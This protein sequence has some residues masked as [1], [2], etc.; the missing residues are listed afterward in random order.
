MNQT[1]F[2]LGTRA[3]SFAEL[4]LV[5]LAVLV[6][7]VLYLIISIHRSRR[8]A[9]AQVQAEA[10]RG[11][12][13]ETH[14]SELMRIQNEL[15]GRMQTMAEVFGTRQSDLFKAVSERMD[16]M[17]HRLGQSMTEHN[18]STNDTLRALQ[19]RLAVIDTAQQ[20]ITQLSGQVVELQ[21]IL[22]NKQTRGAFG[23]GRM[24]A[25]VAD[26]LASNA[27]EFQAT[28]SNASRPDC[29]IFLPNGA[30]SLVIDAK[31]PL[32]AWNAWRAAEDA[33]QV[34]TAV[35]QFRTDMTKHIQDIRQKYFIP[36]ETQDTA[37]LFVPS[38]S[39]FADLHERFEGII[40]AAHKARVVIV[41]PSLLLLSIQVVQAVLRDAKL[42]E[43]AHV[44]QDEVIKLAA[45]V[46]R[47]GDRVEKLQTH[48]GQANRDIEQ[49]LISTS[50][51]ES[52]GRRIAE[53]DFDG[54]NASSADNTSQPDLLRK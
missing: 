35:A 45:D 25:I 50:K 11:A 39:I 51:V 36:G 14:V 15:T 49:I 32:E 37:F 21:H 44:I 38:E 47:L 1:A 46:Q 18:K 24:E 12:E 23:Q 20:N 34:K 28:L 43:Q 29:L 31:F 40:Q 27:Y 30:P 6:L 16:G 13:L 5:A 52:R 26:G 2:T 48:F 33:A 4:A 19:E 41:S 54:E 3:I 17:S 42:R 9:L 8:E 10:S 7:G 22:A 53:L